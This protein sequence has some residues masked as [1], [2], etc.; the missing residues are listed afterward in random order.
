MTWT[1]VQTFPPEALPKVGWFQTRH[2]VTDGV[3]TRCE[4]V[5]WDHSPTVAQR[6][7]AVTQLLFRLN[8]PPPRDTTASEIKAALVAIRDNGALT[9]AQKM[10]AVSN[11]INSIVGAD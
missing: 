5:K 2:Q 3:D 11:Y 7:A 1:L 6:N 8:N 10:Q 9:A 4:F